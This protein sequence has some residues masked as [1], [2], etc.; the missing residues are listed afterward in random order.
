M[1]AFEKV[2][3]LV[4]VNTVIPKSALFFIL[5]GEKNT[6]RYIQ[7]AK[8]NGLIREISYKAKEVETVTRWTEDVLEITTKGVQFVHENMESIIPWVHYLQKQI[9]RIEFYG[10]P[11]SIKK[12]VTRYARITAAAIMAISIGARSD[13]VC[14]S[15]QP[16]DDGEVKNQDIQTPVDE[17]EALLDKE[18]DE[19][20]YNE[21]ELLDMELDAMLAE[22]QS[23]VRAFGSI[24]TN[25][26]EKYINQINNP[27]Y[28]SVYSEGRSDLEFIAAPIIKRQISLGTANEE[29]QPDIRGGRYCGILHSRKRA[30][31]VYMVTPASQ[32]KWSQYLQTKENRAYAIIKRLR[33]G[34]AREDE[35]AA[36]IIVFTSVDLFKYT[37]DELRPYAIKLLEQNG[38][39]GNGVKYLWAIPY[40]RDGCKEMYSVMETDPSEENQRAVTQLIRTGEFRLNSEI[41]SELLQLCTKSGTLV[42]VNVHLDIKFMIQI[43]R[44]VCNVKGKRFGVACFEWQVP[45]YKA[46]LGD[47]VDIIVVDKYLPGY[48]QA[49]ESI[50]PELDIEIEARNWKRIL[51]ND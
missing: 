19:I 5:D 41:N 29:K 1:T 51:R 11:T 43:E 3:Y 45:Y 37:Y 42:A 30:A 20:L 48:I 35:N 49:W 12:R 4:F 46:V 38:K 2:M 50:D 24:I 9:D 13:P 15:F 33:I 21:E 23:C 44:T 47:S 39:Y 17:E 40:S 18:L 10:G 16:Q 32:L 8:E 6:Y 36:G 31:L 26:R 7:K 22:D 28:F 27:R 25:A 14:F 34:Y